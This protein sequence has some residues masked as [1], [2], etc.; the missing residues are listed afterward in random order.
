[1]MKICGLMP[2]SGGWQI[3]EIGEKHILT[4]SILTINSDEK[5]FLTKSILTINSGEKHLEKITQRKS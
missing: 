3:K 4:K 1:M 2:T 5:H